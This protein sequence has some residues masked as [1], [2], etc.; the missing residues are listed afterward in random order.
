MEQRLKL[1]SDS[2]SEGFT[3]GLVQSIQELSQGSQSYRITFNVKNS[4]ISYKAGDRLEVLPANTQTIVKRML[5][6]LCV[7]ASDLS[8]SS[9]CVKVD[10]PEWRQAISRFYC[11]LADENQFPLPAVLRIME[12][13]PLTRGMFDAISEAAGMKGDADAEKAFQRGDLNDV[14]DLITLLHN[15]SLFLYYLLLCFKQEEKMFILCILYVHFVS[16]HV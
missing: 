2:V 12:L 11:E 10:T 8:E 6:S 4:G 5:L 9:M 13:R 14:P 3:L 1:Q 15:V 7:D 16:R